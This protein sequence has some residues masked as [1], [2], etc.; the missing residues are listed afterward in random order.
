MT[1]AVSEWDGSPAH[2]SGLSLKGVYAV[3]V[4]VCPGREECFSFTECKLF[5]QFCPSLSRVNQTCRSTVVSMSS[6]DAHSVALKPVLVTITRNYSRYCAVAFCCVH[7]CSHMCPGHYAKLLPHQ[8]KLYQ[9]RCMGS[10][11]VLAKS[12]T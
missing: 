1:C 9:I 6:V 11:L 2:Y 8:V 4:F 10:G 5:H 12:V 3:M 7:K